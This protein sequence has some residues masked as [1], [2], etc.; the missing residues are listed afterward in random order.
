MLAPDRCA[1]L[2]G[3]PLRLPRSSSGG[4]RGAVCRR[5][6]SGRRVGTGFWRGPSRELEEQGFHWKPASREDFGGNEVHTQAYQ[7]A[8]EEQGAPGTGI[9]ARA[10]ATKKASLISDR[11]QL[12]PHAGPGTSPR[13]LQSVRG[14]AWAPAT[15]PRR[16]E[17]SLLIT[18]GAGEGEPF[19]PVPVR[20]SVPA[21]SPR[22]GPPLTH[23]Q[24]VRPGPCSLAGSSR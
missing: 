13:G 15:H 2:G 14:S 4:E 18:H 12:C 5:E 24:G 17:T 20:F 19:S 21:A 23:L 1:L 7:A 6:A 11:P 16:R 22:K 3:P 9:Q 8:S 10:V